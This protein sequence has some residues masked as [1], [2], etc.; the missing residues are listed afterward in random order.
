ML[1]ANG[2]M[3]QIQLMARDDLFESKRRDVTAPPP[4]YAPHMIRT[5]MNRSDWA[6]LLAL[7]FIWGGAFFCISVAVQSVPPLTYVWLRLTI[8]AAGLWVFRYGR[9]DAP[10]DQ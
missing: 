4:G 8:A 10:E 7:A 9:G 6:I 3:R 1:A 5:V 2:C